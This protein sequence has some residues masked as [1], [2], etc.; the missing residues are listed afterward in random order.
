MSTQGNEHIAIYPFLKKRYKNLLQIILGICL[1]CVTTYIYHKGFM[2]GMKVTSRQQKT[3][4]RKQLLLNNLMDSFLVSGSCV[5]MLTLWSYEGILTRDIGWEENRPA[6]LLRPQQ[7]QI[8]V[9]FY[10]R[11]FY[12]AYK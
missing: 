4:Y 7:V 12:S 11:L 3:E 5:T 6:G 8:F 2:F 9:K 1:Y 10:I